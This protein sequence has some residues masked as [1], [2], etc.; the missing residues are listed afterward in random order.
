MSS[1]R[2]KREKTEKF[3]IYKYIQSDSISL[4]N[5]FSDVLILVLLF[6]DDVVD[7]FES[8]LN[9]LLS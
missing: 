6:D 1:K 7:E 2:E 5:D 8:N 4:F 3:Y 9:C